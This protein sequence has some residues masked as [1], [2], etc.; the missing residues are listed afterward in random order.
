MI[1]VKGL[2]SVSIVREGES[3]LGTL[4]LTDD[5]KGPAARTELLISCALGQDIPLP[6]GYVA[7]SMYRDHC[8]YFQVLLTYASG[9]QEI[10]WIECFYFEMVSNDSYRKRVS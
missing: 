4:W 3:F 8:R 7:R 9:Q 10:R 1:D 5:P 2:D 6:Q